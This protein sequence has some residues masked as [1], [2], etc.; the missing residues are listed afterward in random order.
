MAALCLMLGAAAVA[1]GADTADLRW[2]HSVQKT[3]WR[4]TWRAS[5]EGLQL[6]QAAVQGSGAGMDPGADAVLRD[7]FWVWRPKLP[8]Q[9]EL[10][11]TRSP[12]TGNDWTICPA[13]HG[14]RPL[15]SYFPGVAADQAV[16]LKPCS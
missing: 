13:G 16:T 3:E 5:P 1:L 2:I 6:E 11:L 4:E 9:A 10:V 14:C 8:P 12:Y 15:G 7:G